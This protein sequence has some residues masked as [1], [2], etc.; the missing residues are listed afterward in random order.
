LLEEKEEGVGEDAMGREGAS[1]ALG[2]KAPYCCRVGEEARE[3]RKWRLGG[4]WKIAKCKE[5][6]PLFIEKC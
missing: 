2:K 5:G 1:C 4:R 3:K 6:A